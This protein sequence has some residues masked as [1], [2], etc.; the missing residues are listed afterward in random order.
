MGI[1]SRV[2]DMFYKVPENGRAI[3]EPVNFNTKA[4]TGKVCYICAGDILVNEATRDFKGE[5]VHKRCF[6]KCKKL[7][8][9][10][11]S[12]EAIQKSLRGEK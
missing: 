2:K 3:D 4:S 1:F 8:L 10:G 5:P 7:V 9:Q 12:L 6:K 11:L